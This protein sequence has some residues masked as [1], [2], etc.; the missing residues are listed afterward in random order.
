MKRLGIPALLG[1]IL[2]LAGS[3]SR[4]AQE[5]A[6]DLYSELRAVDKLVLAQMTVSKMATIRDLR[7]DEAHGAR[8][9]SAALLDALKLGDRKAAY[10]YN[11]Y[12]RAFVDLSQMRPEDVVTDDAA[13]TISITLPPIQTEFAGR[14]PGIREDH[15]LFI[16]L[17]KKKR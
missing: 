9:I 15:I 14:D 2:L 13:R 1:A 3:C 6:P 10:S 7:L 4:P 12:L 8:Q 17:L 5:T 16:L 11:T